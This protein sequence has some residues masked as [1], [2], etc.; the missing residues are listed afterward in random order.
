MTL[1]ASDFRQVG[2]QTVTAGGQN[3]RRVTQK[4]L[5][6]SDRLQQGLDSLK[7]ERYKASFHRGSQQPS[8]LLTERNRERERD[9]HRKREKKETEKDKEQEIERETERA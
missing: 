2:K 7:K 8:K 4:T 9:K 6:V 5:G 3:Q 1:Q